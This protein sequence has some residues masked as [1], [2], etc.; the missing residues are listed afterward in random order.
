MF[1]T[2]FLYIMSHTLTHTLSLS[3]A[4]AKLHGID[5]AVIGVI[6]LIAGAILFSMIRHKKRGGGCYGCPY[7]KTCGM[8]RRGGCPSAGQNHNPPNSAA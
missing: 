4:A 7:G 8:A 6:L 2:G 3:C 1:H 5:Y